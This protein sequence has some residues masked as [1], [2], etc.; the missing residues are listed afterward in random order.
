MQGMKS[1]TNWIIG[2]SVLAL[3]ALARYCGRDHFVPGTGQWPTVAPGEQERIIVDGRR[4]TRITREGTTTSIVP[5]GAVVSVS[6]AGEVT[7]KAKRIGLCFQPGGA[8]IRGDRWKLA[9]DVKMA[10]FYLLGFHAGIT[11]DLNANRLGNAF[12]GQL[13]VSY[14]LPIKKFEN[15][16]IYV[17]KELPGGLFAGIRVGF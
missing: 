12:K 5:N 9:A 2:L 8:V 10:Y 17:G 14:T 13:G 16:S 1:K 4:I 3:L 7:F 6:D 11:A 15:T